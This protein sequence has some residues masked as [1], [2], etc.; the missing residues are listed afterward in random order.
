M[1]VILDF[2]FVPSS[3]HTCVSVPPER[4]GSCPCCPPGPAGWSWR[5]ACPRRSAPPAGCPPAAASPT[6]GGTR[7]PHRTSAARCTRSPWDSRGHSYAIRATV[8]QSGATVTQSGATVTQSGTTVTQSGP[9]LRNQ[10][11]Q[12]RNQGPLLHNQGH[13]YA[14]RA[15]VT[16]SGA[17]VTQSGATVTQ[18]ETTVTQ[19]GATVTQSGA[20]VTQSVPLLRNQGPQLRN[21]GH[22]YAIRA[23]VTQSGAT[24]MQ[25]GATVTQSGPL[26]RNQ[27]HCYA[28]RG[29]SYAIRDHCYAISD[30]SYAISVTYVNNSSSSS[31]SPARVPMSQ[32][33]S[34]LGH[35][36]A[37]LPPGHAAD[38]AGVGQV[39]EGEVNGGRPLLRGVVDRHRRA[40]PGGGVPHLEQ[41]VILQTG[42]HVSLGPPQQTNKQTNSTLWSDLPHGGDVLPVW[43]PLGDVD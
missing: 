18:S 2:P 28:I 14:I 24:V 9:L 33:G 19:S 27:G 11:P 7:R 40:P 20:T 29:H 41:T 1:L 16:Q 12:L 23:T 4:A 31:S 3:R 30:H 36:L 22:S 43:R 6:T 21:Q 37:G 26:L 17:T 34:S 15:T 5:S 42:R 39:N 38:G 13:C 35:V 32:A 8:T 25:S 10:G